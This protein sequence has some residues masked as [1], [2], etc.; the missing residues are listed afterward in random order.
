MPHVST[1]KK[2]EDTKHTQEAT[3]V[4]VKIGGEEAK[5]PAIPPKKTPRKKRLRGIGAGRHSRLT[6]ELLA[7]IR[8]E[9]EKGKPKE[10]VQK[11]LKI[12]GST[13]RLWEG[14]N[15]GGFKDMVLSSRYAYMVRKAE[16]K[17]AQ[18]L[19]YDIDPKNSRFTSIIQK[20]AEYLR[21]NLARGTYS[22]RTEVDGNNTITVQIASYLSKPRNLESVI[23]VS[24]NE[25]T[26]L[27]GNPGE[28]DTPLNANEVGDD[29][30]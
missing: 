17:S 22:T 18:L 12:A 20:E 16:E 6:E 9:L 28:V 27:L 10:V 11:Q 4:I 15:Y 13:W 30:V 24:A 1:E 26:P 5:K 19:S 2:E 14:Q 3:P 29:V 7:E 8:E 23:D 25:K 21:S